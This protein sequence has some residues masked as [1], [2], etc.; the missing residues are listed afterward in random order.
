MNISPDSPDTNTFALG[1][2]SEARAGTSAAAA[3]AGG[4]G[5]SDEGKEEEEKEGD[6][7]EDVEEE[8]FSSADDTSEQFIAMQIE[9]AKS[10]FKR[11][12]DELNVLTGASSGEEHT[13]R[14]IRASPRLSAKR[15]R[16]AQ[17]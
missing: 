2:L 12:L 14:R 6:G 8:S 11:Q 10:A 4:G 9:Q 5:A 16:N 15:A 1:L 13:D 7:M 17:L 3:A